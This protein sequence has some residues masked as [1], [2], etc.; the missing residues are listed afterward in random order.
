ME[1]VKK[2]A[3]RR[4]R[5]RFELRRQLR[6]KVA[7]EGVVVA[8]G[9]GETINIGSGGVAFCAENRLQ[10]GAFV[11]L[12]ISWPMLLDE[13]CPMRL[14]V[15]G[16]VLRSQGNRAACSVDKYEFRTQ[17]RKLEPISTGRTDSMLQRW[18]DTV[19]KNELK[20]NLLGA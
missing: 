2:Q 20:M 12:S 11:E 18:V 1:L 4:R 3:E 9:A 16:R 13:N 19:R 17:S 15:F 5:R 8:S 6:Y 14:T 10:P 7:E